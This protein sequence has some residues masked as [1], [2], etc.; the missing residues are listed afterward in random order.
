MLGAGKLSFFRGG[1]RH[2]DSNHTESLWLLVMRT[3]EHITNYTSIEREGITLQIVVELL[4]TMV[5]REMLHFSP[6]HVE[7]Q[8]TFASSSRRELFN[9]LFADFLEPVDPALL[10]SKESLLDV[11]YRVAKEPKL[12]D[13]I[14]A[15]PLL[16]AVTELREWLDQ[17]I[18]PEVWFPS[19]NRNVNLK[20]RRAQFITICGNISKH[21]LSRLTRNAKR[22]AELFG[23]NGIE[24]N[25]IDALRAL[26]DFNVRF[27][28][29]IFSYHSTTM[30]ELLN[31]V[32]WGIHE[33]L[34]P[35]FARSFTPSPIPDDPKYSYTFPDGL[36]DPFAQERYWDLMMFP[37][38]L[39]Q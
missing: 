16:W 33:Y 22:L 8:V 1:L 28:E 3:D 5:N 24:L 6:G 26:D 12:G 23:D 11:L 38:F 25:W 34:E 10:G 14:V 18:Q 39:G 35:E 7:I 36:Q 32:R 31:N 21:S 29:D 2:H 20:L 17:T 19:I 37:R 30:T 15:S 27:Q 4:Q 9:V 13:T